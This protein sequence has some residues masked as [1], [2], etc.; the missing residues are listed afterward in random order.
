MHAASMPCHAPVL[1]T[2]P[3]AD[4]GAHKQAQEIPDAEQRI[5]GQAVKSGKVSTGIRLY[6]GPRA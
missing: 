1:A 5:E 4:A 2:R 6:V 3:V